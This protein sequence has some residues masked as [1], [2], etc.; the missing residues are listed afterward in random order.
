M[1]L[2]LIGS[3]VKDYIHIHK[4]AEEV[5]RPGGLYYSAKGLKTVLSAEDQAYIFTA[6]SDET[7][8]LFEPVYSSFNDKYI[9]RTPKIPV[10]HLNIWSEHG[11][12]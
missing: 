10:V 3:S 1:R 11:S 4:D 6:V 2:L 5:V 8:S 7:C 9:I 12:I